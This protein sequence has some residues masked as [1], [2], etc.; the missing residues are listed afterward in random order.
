MPFLFSLLKNIYLILSCSTCH[1]VVAVIVLVPR[2]LS[3]WG[4][5]V[6]SA[7]RSIFLT[8]KMCNWHCFVCSCFVSFEASFLNSLQ[9]SNCVIKGSDLCN[10]ITRQAKAGWQFYVCPWWFNFPAP[11]V[12]TYQ[13]SGNGIGCQTLRSWMGFPIARKKLWK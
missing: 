13:W 4:L 5:I 9:F 2:F 8:I 10:E 11:Q 7:Q 12:L 3:K 6:V 1:H